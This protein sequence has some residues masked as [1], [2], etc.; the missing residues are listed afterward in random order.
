MK[1]FAAIVLGLISISFPIQ[2]NIEFPGVQPGPFKITIRNG[3]VVVANN[4]ISTGWSTSGPGLKMD[5]LEDV[6][7]KKSVPID[8]EP[9]QIVLAD[10]SRY[11]ASSLQRNGQPIAIECLPDPQ[12]SRLAGRI[13]GRQVE[14]SLLSSDGRLKVRWHAIALEGSNYI[15][16]EIAI[17]P[18]TGDVTIRE[19]IWMDQRF[20]E[21]KTLGLVDGS[22]VLAD[23]FFLGYEDPMALNT[24][25]SQGTGIRVQCRLQRNATLRKGVPLVQS[26]VIGVAPPGQTRR[27]FLYYL[28][29]ERAHPYRPFL[30]YNAWFDIC[31]EGVALD[32]SMCLT[33]I[34]GFG[35]NLIKPYGVVMDSMVID[36]GWDD[37][38]TLWQFNKGFPAGFTALRKLCGDYNTSV[39]VWLSPFG[40][41]GRNKEERLKYGRHQGFEINAAGFSLAGPNYNERFKSE[42][43]RMIREYGANYFK[44]DGI[45]SGMYANG[46]GSDYIL[47]TEA[48]RQLMLELRKEASDVFINL[49]TGSWP[50]PFWLRYADSLWRQ[51]EDTSFAGKG[52]P[53]QRWITY[54][55]QETFRNIVGKGQLYPLNSLMT[56]G[57]CYSRYGDPGNPQFNSAGLKEDIRSFFGSGT[58][59]QELYLMPQKLK[60]EDWRVLAESSKWSRANADVLSDTHWIG[61]DPGKGQV[62]GW[63]SWSLRK[64]IITLRN[65]DNRAQRYMLELQSAFELPDGGP[66]RYTLK[67]PWTEDQHKPSVQGTAGIPFAIVLQ[68]F[69]ILTLEAVH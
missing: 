23:T 32:E 63:A 26:F 3:N 68:P 51:G 15:R 4:V 37:P 66:H 62:Y 12:S 55:D 25:S 20:P 1:R 29:R 57:V 18:A 38:A 39:G 41:Y 60:S 8:A 42:C 30:H 54:R 13:A 31:W 67:S 10:G 48:M 61:G 27:A 36:D 69:E 50:S 34:R 44:F 53:Q 35:E 59:L 21:A 6:Q 22:P 16:Q 19:I 11:T 14:V 9:F 46:A 47:D 45:A 33:A 17:L 7:A 40:G 2:A 28:E 52:T 58:C 43:L 64:G 5:F 56:C 65:P 24:V 49:T